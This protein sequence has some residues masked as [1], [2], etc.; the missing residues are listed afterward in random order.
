MSWAGVLLLGAGA[1]ALKAVGLLILGE[2]PLPRRLSAVVPLLPVALLSALVVVQTFADGDDLGID[3][4]MAGM[5]VAAGAV[6]LRAPFLIV[7]ASAA[8]T[9]ALLRLVG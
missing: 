6:A 7:V 4:R 8:L 5:A 9:A 2:R 3:A 1:Y